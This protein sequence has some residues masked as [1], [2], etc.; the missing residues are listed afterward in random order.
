[1]PRSK[2]FDEVEVL[3]K[4]MDLFWKKGYYATSM[5]DL[6]TQL[7]INRASL[8]DTYGGKRELFNRAF[9]H[10]IKANTAGI[11]R[12]LASQ[13]SVREGLRAL[14][15]TA[16]RQSCSDADQKGCF[17]VNTTVELIPNEADAQQILE[18]NKRQHESILYNYLKGGEEK[19]E[20]PK[21]KNLKAIAT[22]LFTFYN[23]LKVVTKVDF[24]Q[25]Q[26]SE[27]VDALLGILD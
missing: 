23:G 22:L 20:I 27:S 12:F 17:V 4:A 19:G 3:E 7:G 13:P 11:Q 21:G 1:M 16:I 8:Y 25:E 9:S 6:V 18:D 26:F 15:E 24:Q 2:S 10:Y 14:F 5:Q